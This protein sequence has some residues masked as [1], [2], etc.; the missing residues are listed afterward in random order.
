MNCQSCGT[1]LPADAQFCI[2]CGVAVREANTN[3]TVALPP[4]LDP[5]LRC[6]A[7]GSANPE[8]ALFCVRCGERIDLTQSTTLARRATDPSLAP[9][10]S[11]PTPLRRRSGSRGWPYSGAFFLI[12]LGLIFLLKLPFLPAL[13]VMIGLT[14]FIGLAISG[15][16]LAGLSPLIW[17][18]ALAIFFAIPRLG[19][20]AIFVA[21]GLQF[22]LAAAHRKGW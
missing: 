20:P 13:F 3:P 4:T 16:A 7:C 11:M 12:G 1:E 10:P 17:M 15:N 18:F 8:H 14:T 9:A 5:A 19:V 22:I 6:P 21:L 2:E